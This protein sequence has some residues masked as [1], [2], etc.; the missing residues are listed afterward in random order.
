MFIPSLLLSY[1]RFTLIPFPAGF[2]WCSVLLSSS[3]IEVSSMC[4]AYALTTV[5][6]QKTTVHYVSLV[7]LKSC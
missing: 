7:N 1:E 3:L 2:L 4:K 6:V 5:N